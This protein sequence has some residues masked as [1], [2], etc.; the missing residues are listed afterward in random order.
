MSCVFAD[1]HNMVAILTKSEASQGFD[2][3]IDFLNGSYIKYALTV[4]PHI[5]VSCIKQFWN[6]VTVKQS[7]DVT[8]LQALVDRKKVMILEAVIRDVLC[9]ADAEGVDCLP[10]EEIFTGWLNEFSSAMASAII[11][12]FIGRKF[13]FSKYI[14][15]SLV[16]NV[17]SSSKFYMYPRVGK[18]C[19]VV[20]T[21]LFEGMLVGEEPEEQG[22]TDEQVQGNDNDAAQEGVTAAEVE[23]VQEPSI[24][25]PTPPPQPQDLPSTSQVEEGGTSQRVDTSDDTVMEDVSNQGRMIDEL[26]RDEGVALMGEKKEEKKAEEVKDIAGDAQIDM[27][28]PSKVLS[29]QEDE[30][31]EVEEVVVVVTTAKLITKVVTAASTLVSAASTLIP[32]A[33]PKVPASTPTTALVSVVAV[34]STR[35]RKGV[36]IS[37]PKKKSIAIKPTDTKS[38]DKGKG[39]MSVA[40]DHVKQK[41]KEDKYVQKYQVMKKIPQTEAQAR[42]NMITYLKNE[43]IEE[44]ENRAIKS[45][46][47]TLAQK[48]AKRRKLNEEIKD[49]EDLKQ[50]LEIVPDEDDDVYTEA[51]PL[52]RKVPIVDYQIIQLN[53]KPRYK[54]IKADGT[55]Q[56]YSNVWKTR[57]TRSNLEESKECPWSS[58]VEKRYLLSK[59]TLDQMLN[60]VRLQVEEE[61]EMSLELLSAA[62]QKLMLLDTAAESS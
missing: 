57:W 51:A 23:D 44:E 19:S 4:N 36:V 21:P 28:H 17:D 41:A 52:A 34:A 6:T 24:S 9:L 18:G 32:A 29:M 46:N 33:E 45:I 62:K 14:F 48:A 1:T 54:I 47:E 49:V 55:H 50:H 38:K 10:N 42:R 7:N 56:L 60:A 3:I 39:I 2:Q 58:K 20:E 8:R 53:N 59:F 25:S 40:I 11:C 43:Q 15:D 27:D 12:L 16:I 22:D 13:N 61:S 37:D 5:Y 26:D 35:R 31:A 30:P